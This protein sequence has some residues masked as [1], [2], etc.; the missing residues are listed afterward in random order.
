VSISQAIDAGSD[1]VCPR[2]DQLGRLRIGPCDIGAIAFRHR[3]DRQH[4][5][6]EDHHDK[7]LAAAAD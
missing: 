4:D 6:E 7:D 3:D 2:T 1:A 5:E